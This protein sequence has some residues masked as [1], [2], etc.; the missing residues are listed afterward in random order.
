MSKSYLFVK[1]SV[2]HYRRVPLKK[3]IIG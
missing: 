3:K 1:V 2:L